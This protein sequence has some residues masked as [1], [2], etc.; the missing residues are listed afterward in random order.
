M[1]WSASA[2]VNVEDAD[3]PTGKNRTYRSSA[4][5]GDTK[6]PAPVRSAVVVVKTFFHAPADVVKVTLVDCFRIPISVH[7]HGPDGRQRSGEIDSVFRNLENDGAAYEMK[8]PDDRFPVRLDGV[9]SVDFGVIKPGQ[10]GRLLSVE[11]VLLGVVIPRIDR[12]GVKSVRQLP[13]TP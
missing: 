2:T 3:E 1:I 13:F 10:V 12:P 6:I 4:D 5:A 8:E 9:P 11:R 7:G